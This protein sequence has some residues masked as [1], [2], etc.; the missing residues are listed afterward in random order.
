MYGRE[1]GRRRRGTGQRTC[2]SK[3]TERH[4]NTSTPTLCPCKHP[5]ICPCKHPLICPSQFPIHITSLTAASLPLPCGTLLSRTTP[6]TLLHIL[7]SLVSHHRTILRTLTRFRT[8][9]QSHHTSNHTEIHHTSNCK[10]THSYLNLPRSIPHT[11]TRLQPH[12]HNTHTPL[13][14]IQN[15]A[16]TK[17][18]E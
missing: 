6:F 1:R 5:L 4:G 8:H 16:H 12:I 15:T 17:A 2:F 10:G 3:W 11:C 9:T 18:F 7:S 13:P 14:H